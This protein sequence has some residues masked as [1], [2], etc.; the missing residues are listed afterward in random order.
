[1]TEKEQVTKHYVEYDLILVKR[2]KYIWIEKDLEGYA[3]RC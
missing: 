1:M 3:L 2:C